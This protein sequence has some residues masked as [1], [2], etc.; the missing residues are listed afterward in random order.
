MDSQGVLAGMSMTLR[1]LLIQGLATYM[2]SL[3]I[4][5]SRALAHE[6]TV[7][8][9]AHVAKAQASHGTEATIHVPFFPK[10]TW[11]ELTVGIPWEAYSYA[12]GTYGGQAISL[13]TQALCSAPQ[14]IDATLATQPVFSKVWGGSLLVAIGKILE[15]VNHNLV[16]FAPYWRAKGVQAL[17]AAAGRRSYPDIQVLIFTQPKAMMQEE[18]KEGLNYFIKT[19][20]EAGAK[21]SVLAP[22]QHEGFT[23]ILHAKVVIG[24][25]VKAYIGSANFTKSGLDHGLEAGVLV[26]G[27]IANQFSVWARTVE[28]I[29]VPW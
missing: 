2:K 25:G 5:Q 28:T 19:L 7:A 21:V 10:E 24:D 3:S 13:G 1:A 16:V 9:S 22:E 11:N 15:G 18:D 4:A 8:V 23:P 17:L 14:H 12:Y 26:D 27:E 6:I 20:R 29:C